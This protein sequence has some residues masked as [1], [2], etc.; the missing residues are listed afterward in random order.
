MRCLMNFL[1][2]KFLCRIKVKYQNKKR[3]IKAHEILEYKSGD[4]H[5]IVSP[6]RE[7]GQET[8]LVKKSYYMFLQPVLSG[9]VNL[10]AVDYQRY[11]GCC[12]SQWVRKYYLQKGNLPLESSKEKRKENIQLIQEMVADNI[13]LSSSID[14]QKF[15]RGLDNEGHDDVCKLI[16]AYNEGE[17][18]LKMNL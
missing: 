5:F 16:K 12:V 10:Y 17:A 15:D 6:F 11:S 18:N 9:K 14:W 1:I 8:A 2:F 3:V 4:D 7:P 13:E